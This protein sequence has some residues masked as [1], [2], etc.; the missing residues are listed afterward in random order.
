MKLLM[1]TWLK[2][3]CWEKLRSRSDCST[4][5]ICVAMPYRE[6]NRAS[7]L[8]PSISRVWMWKR[9]L[10]AVYSA[11]GRATFDRQMF[12]GRERKLKTKDRDKRL[13]RFPRLENV[14]LYRSQK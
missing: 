10:R 9:T 3:R 13:T 4:C 6:T 14:G 5:W 1:E 2:A 12:N 7:K 11:E 8:V